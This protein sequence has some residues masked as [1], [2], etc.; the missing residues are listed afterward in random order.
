M[1]CT[2]LGL[3]LTWDLASLLVPLRLGYLLLPLT[4]RALMVL[5]PTTETHCRSIF[6]L[7]RKTLFRSGTLVGLVVLVLRLL[8]ML[9]ERT[10]KGVS[11]QHVNRL[12]EGRGILIT[13]T[14]KGCCKVCLDGPILALITVQDEQDTKDFIQ[15]VVLFRLLL[16]LCQG[17]P[18]TLLLTEEIKQV[19]T[20][21]GLQDVTVLFETLDVL[22]QRHAV[23]LLVV[24]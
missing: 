24:E 8:A 2:T 15:H 9:L 11:V 12:S 20:Q 16:R 1:R 13:P 4:V 18:T 23:G 7:L 6:L 10:V 14:R 22:G 17:V 5:G 19:V 3:H 21:L